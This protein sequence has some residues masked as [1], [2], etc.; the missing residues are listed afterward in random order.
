LADEAPDATAG[1]IYLPGGYPELHAGRLAGSACFLDG[2]RGAARRGAVIYG[3]CGGYMLLGQGLEDAEGARHAMAGL[4]P[5]ESS[6]KAPQRHLGYRRS[7]IRAAGPLGPAGTA[8]RGHEFHYACV[9]GAEGPSETALFDAA[10]VAAGGPAG[11][12]LAVG[13]RSGAV[14]GSFLHLVDREAC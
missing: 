5:L 7:V 6:F 9:V 2:L 10:P 4:L 13:Q 1:A 8:Y 11:L 14:F 12:P 3:E